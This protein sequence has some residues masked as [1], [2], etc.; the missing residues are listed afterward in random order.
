MERE[1]SAKRTTPDLCGWLP[2]LIG[3]HTLTAE[4]E[5]QAGQDSEK[6]RPG[7]FLRHGIA[8]RS[9]APSASAASYGKRGI[10]SEGKQS[11]DKQSKY[12]QSSGWQ[13]DTA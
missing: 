1:P 6:A 8:L 5:S 4:P 11:K 3:C 7:G 13:E 9:G 10:Q 2:L 12:K